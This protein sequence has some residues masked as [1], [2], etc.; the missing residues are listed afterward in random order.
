[1]INLQEGAGLPQTF[2]LLLALYN[3]LT[4]EILDLLALSVYASAHQ[5]MLSNLY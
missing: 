4:R 1:M 2:I 5:K 3:D